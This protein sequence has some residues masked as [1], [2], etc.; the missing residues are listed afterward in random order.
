MSH[1]I[2]TELQSRHMVRNTEIYKQILPLGNAPSQPIKRKEAQKISEKYAYKTH[3]LD[4]SMYTLM[5]QPA[6]RTSI[7]FDEQVFR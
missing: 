3:L 5:Y 4:I 2:P 7:H 1:L 6:T